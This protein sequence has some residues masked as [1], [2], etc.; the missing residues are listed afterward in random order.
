[1]HATATRSSGPPCTTNVLG[2]EGSK[3]GAATGDRLESQRTWSDQRTYGTPP[4][5][6]TDDHGSIVNASCLPFRCSHPVLEQTVGPEVEPLR[7]EIPD[8]D[9]RRDSQVAQLSAYPLKHTTEGC[10]AS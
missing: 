8:R 10:G 1:M 5:T 3:S 9:R 2:V 4:P 6:T 7:Q